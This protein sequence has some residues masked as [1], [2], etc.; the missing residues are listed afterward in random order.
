[1]KQYPPHVIRITIFFVAM[2]TLI[3]EILLTRFYSITYLHNYAFFA[4]AISMF[5]ITIGSVIV[6]MAQRKRTSSFLLKLSIIIFPISIIFSMHLL[7]LSPPIIDSIFFL[8][9]IT[10]LP[11]IASGII[12]SFIFTNYRHDISKLYALDLIGAALGCWAIIL[13]LNFLDGIS[14]YYFEAS[15]GLILA[16]YLLLFEKSK[17]MAFTT[18]TASLICILVVIANGIHYKSTGKALLTIDS[19]NG[20][21]NHK[22][23][24]WNANS[25]ISI[26]QNPKKFEHPMGWGFSS[27]LPPQPLIEQMHLTIDGHAYTIIPKFD[28]DLTKHNYLRY[29]IINIGHYIRSHGNVAI[30][31]SGGGRDIVSSLVF[32]QKNITGIEV[33]KSIVQVNQNQLKHFS[34][35]L[36]SR[37]NIQI[38]NDEARN[39]FERIDKR[40][41]LIQISLIDTWAAVA[42]G[43]LALAENSLYTKEAWILFLKRLNDN[44]ILSISRWYNK[45]KPVSIQRLFSLAYQSLKLQGIINPRLH[46]AALYQSHTTDSNAFTATVLISPAPLENESVT[47]LNNLV[48]KFKYKW[49]FDPRKRNSPKFEILLNSKD[50]EQYILESNYNIQAPTDDR[51]FF[52]QFEKLKIKSLFFINKTLKLNFFKKI[53]W[54]VLLTTIFLIIFQVIIIIKDKTF[55]DLLPKISF[56]GLT[57]FGFMLIEISL[58]QKLIIYLGHPIYSLS[59]AL[60]T[61]LLSCGIGSALTDKYASIIKRSTF[62]LIPMVQLICLLLFNVM[63]KHFIGIGNIFRIISCIIF[64]LPIGI[65][66]GVMIPSGIKLLEPKYKNYIPVLWGINGTMS[67]LGSVIAAML[68]MNLGANM[69]F[70]SGIVAYC[71]AIALLRNLQ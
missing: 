45:K 13:L 44:G 33:N 56:F 8:F 42:A 10:A 51:P 12:L 63:T 23:I 38:I 59:V 69:T 68:C 30:V 65:A 20:I 25:R 16:S 29:D 1:M 47:I 14:I 9:V 5:G 40:Y 50:R 58:L 26:W 52:F 43:G 24:F 31:G 27:Q 11:F 2:I 66:M 48:E 55:K 36:N 61:I 4:I 71:C 35:D 6:F 17:K 64:L 57:G 21:K 18:A 7:I 41:D 15:I 67:V 46:I 49:L 39:Y 22:Y 37:K 70:L 19:L 32:K 28:G 54:V 60:F 62:L 3:H 34:G 53:F